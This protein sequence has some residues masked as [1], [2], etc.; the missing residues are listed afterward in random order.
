M[1]LLVDTHVVLWALNDDPRLSGPHRQLLNSDATLV[2]S[3]VTIWEISIKRA[4]GKL[5]APAAISEVIANAGCL[6]LAITWAHA[7]LAGR[8]PMH[9]ADPF[10]RLLIAQAKLEDMPIITADAAFKRYDVELV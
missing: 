5:K 1:K 4:S 10:D 2:V 8:L 9:H 6:P 3:A 7:D